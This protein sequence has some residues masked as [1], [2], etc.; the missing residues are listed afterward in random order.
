MERLSKPSTG[1]RTLAGTVDDLAAESDGSI[2]SPRGKWGLLVFLP[3][4]D[5]LSQ[6][7]CSRY[8]GP[9]RPESCVRRTVAGDKDDKTLG[10][11]PDF[12][13]PVPPGS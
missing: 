6:Q 1:S 10:A 3:D 2:F 12:V 7:R 5:G 9:K 13:E 11:R 4:Q 8:S